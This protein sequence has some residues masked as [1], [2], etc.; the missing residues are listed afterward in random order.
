[1]LLIIRGGE[2]H[3]ID[4]TA[5]HNQSNGGLKITNMQIQF[6]ITQV[7][8]PKLQVNY[9]EIQVNMRKMQV[10]MISLSTEKNLI[11]LFNRPR[12]KIES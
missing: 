12:Q 11:M 2:N 6:E 1:M 8:C 3:N 4:F 9:P 7:K 5:A 10:I